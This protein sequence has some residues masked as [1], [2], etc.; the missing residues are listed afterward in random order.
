ME[1]RAVVDQALFSQIQACVSAGDFS[2]GEALCARVA[3]QESNNPAFSVMRGDI[4]LMAKNH[5]E[6]EAHYRWATLLAPDAAK[7]WL[8]LARACVAVGRDAVA[9]NAAE[10]ALSLNV[11]DQDIA[12]AREIV[13]HAKFAAGDIAAGRDELAALAP[14]YRSVLAGAAKPPDDVLRRALPAALCAGD[15]APVRKIMQWLYPEAGPLGPVAVAPVATLEDWCAKAGV[16]CEV[17]E[18]PLRVRIEATTPH[19]RREAYKTDPILFASIPNGQWVPGWDYAIGS[20]GTVLENS[21]CLKIIHVF[22]HA[23]HAYF[24]AAKLVAHHSPSDVVDIDEDVLFLSAPMHNHIGF[25]INEF[26][27]RLIGRSRA[28]GAGMKVVVPESL[29]GGKFMEMLALAG[30]GEQD[31]IR[32]RLDARYRFR[33]LNIYRSSVAPH[34]IHTR[35]IRNLLYGTPGPAAR[36]RKGKRFFMSRRKVGTRLAINAAEFEACLRQNNFITVELSELTVAQQ[37]DLFADAEVLLSAFGTDQFAM[38]FAPPGCTSITMQWHAGKD[39][40]PFG[41]AM[42]SMAGMRHQFLLC[43]TTRPSKNARHWL[44]FD[45]VVDCAELTRRMQEF[46]AEAV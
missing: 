32:C 17:I 6:A 23:P 24:A 19:S 29:P 35:Y 34:P 41:P 21:G 1:W 27:P 13:A 7:A 11:G 37:R 44:D 45:F 33:T 28:G 25:W 4:A 10:R 3:D 12:A 31:I 5:A 26:L 2:G 8:G 30:I 18:P 42:C 15:P 43:P 14:A 36:P 40:D 39:I 46:D 22:N 20:D 9:G 16:Q 38:Y